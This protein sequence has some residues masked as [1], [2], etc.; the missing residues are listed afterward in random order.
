MSHAGPTP[1]VAPLRDLPRPALARRRPL[2]VLWPADLSMLHVHDSGRDANA[3]W[4]GDR[5]HRSRFSPVA[6]HGGRYPGDDPVPVLYVADEVEG[7][8]SESVFHDI[9]PT[10]SRRRMPLAKLET[11]T[12]TELTPTRDLRLVD[13]RSDGLHR[14]RIS[15]ADLIETGPAYYPQT[16]LWAAALH[17]RV[18][19]Y[20]GMTWVSR[21]FDTSMAA[22]LFGDR[23]TAA[24]MPV[25]R[26]GLALP[27]GVGAGLEMVLERA[28]RIEVTITGIPR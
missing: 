26:G 11:R 4:G 10:G 16:A 28:E 5:A 18:E 27:L 7:A 17:A 21:Q 12:L 13:L 24:E 6:P 19:G 9:A 20:D 15:R 2:E 3:F 22:V 23:V 1:K 14:L 8:L 25:P